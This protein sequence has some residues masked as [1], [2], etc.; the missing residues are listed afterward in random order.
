MYLNLTQYALFLLN[1]KNRVVCM[2]L[3]QV[4]HDTRWGSDGCQTSF[5][6]KEKIPLCSGGVNAER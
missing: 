5:S 1:I 6:P 4:R 2:L 3:F